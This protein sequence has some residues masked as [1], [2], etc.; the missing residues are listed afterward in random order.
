MRERG[1]RRG[2]ER[3]TKKVDDDKVRVTPG[4]DAGVDVLYLVAQAQPR[5]L[6]VVLVPVLLV[7]VALHRQEALQ[8][9]LGGGAAGTAAHPAGLE[10]G[11]AARRD[12]QLAGRQLGEGGEEWG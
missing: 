10:H 4:R 8:A 5:G 6:H 7:C 9:L 1:K 12:E 2:S 11:Q 3:G